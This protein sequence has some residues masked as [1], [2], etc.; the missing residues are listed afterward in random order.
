[1]TRYLTSAE[2]ETVVTFNDA[3]PTAHVFTHQRTVITKL[4]K[5]PAAT[6]L[7]SGHFGKNTWAEYEMPKALI[8]FRT[9]SKAKAA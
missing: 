4:D 9:K 5:N 1:M 6:K 3:D 2:R 8:S 7:E